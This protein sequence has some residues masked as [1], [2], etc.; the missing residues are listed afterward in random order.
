MQLMVC[1]IVEV[2]R[3]AEI[4]TMVGAGKTIEKVETED[5]DIVYTGIT[6]EEFV[7]QIYGSPETF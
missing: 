3:A 1:V 5:D 4:I 6:H 7:S 2:E